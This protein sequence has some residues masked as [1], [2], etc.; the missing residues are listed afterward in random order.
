V[1]ESLPGSRLQTIDGAG[2]MLPLTHKEAVNAAVVEHL[3]RSKA[4]RHRPAA[5]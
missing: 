4:G 5:A 1:T 2:H 3:L